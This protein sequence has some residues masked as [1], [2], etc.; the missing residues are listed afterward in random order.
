[1][2]T[3][4]LNSEQIVVDS[5]RTHSTRRGIL[6]TGA[7]YTPV[8]PSRELEICRR[9]Q[10]GLI[11][12]VNDFFLSSLCTRPPTLKGTIVNVPKD[13]GRK[14]P[15]GEFI[16][17]DTT[18]MLFICGGAFSG[19]EH[20]INNRIAKVSI[21]FGANLPADLTSRD[22]QVKL[23]SSGVIGW[24]WLLNY[25]RVVSERRFTLELSTR[26]MKTFK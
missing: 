13:G 14:N 26:V 7:L 12:L 20:M 24:R 5:S 15:R 8:I 6:R 3:Y 19:L 16:Q 22:T 21:G 17:V 2:H 25:E 4:L 1:M 9:R 11:C 10:L 23:G 18:N